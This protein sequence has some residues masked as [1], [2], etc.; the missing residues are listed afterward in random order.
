MKELP[1]PGAQRRSWLP[2][3]PMIPVVL[4]GIAWVAAYLVRRPEGHA[5]GDVPWHVWLFGI[6]ALVTTM[7]AAVVRQEVIR[8]LPCPQCGAK[9]LDF[10][11]TSRGVLLGCNRC[12]VRWATG[13]RPHD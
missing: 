10:S 11:A 12:S 6:V 7:A 5:W 9:K 2:V 4:T 8:S 13:E 1:Y 3:L